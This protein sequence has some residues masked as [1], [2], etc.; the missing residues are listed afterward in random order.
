MNAKQ[1]L[2]NTIE[3]ARKQ[4][5]A[6]ESEL[7]APVLDGTPWLILQAKAGEPIRMFGD[8]NGT[9]GWLAV[10]AVPDHLCGAYMLSGESAKR[11]E[12]GIP[13]SWKMHVNDFKHGR[14]AELQ[15]LIAG[16]ESL[17]V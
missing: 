2:K 5:S 6:I 14:I 3:S 15:K 17:T 7:S 16:I 1:I 10:E 13:F 12:Q 11:Y 9:K 8:W 4:I